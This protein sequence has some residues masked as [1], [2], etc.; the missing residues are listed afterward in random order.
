MAK[1]GLRAAT[2]DPE[3][4]PDDPRSDRGAGDAAERKAKDGQVLRVLLVEDCEEDSLLLRRTLEQG[5]YAPELYRVEDA[6]GLR[7]ALAEHRW[8]IVLSDYRLPRFTA[9]DALRIIQES[10]LDLPFILV[11]GVVGESAAVQIMK[12]GAHDFVSKDAVARLVP[13]IERELRE[14]DVR[15]Q[16]RRAEHARREEAQISSS[17]ARV[18]KQLIGSM[19]TR[20]VL[21]RLCS[22]AL[23]ELG[24]DASQSFLWESSEDVYLRIS[25]AG[26]PG[27]PPPA[28]GAAKISHALLGDFLRR[29]EVEE[30]AYLAQ[31]PAD[32]HVG[33]LLCPRAP[34]CRSMVTALRR[35]GQIFGFLTMELHETDALFSDQQAR[36]LQGIAQLGALAFENARLV[37]QLER[38]NQLKSEFIATMSHELRTPLNVI[39]G[40]N[41]LLMDNEFGPLSREQTDI[42]QRADR[43]ARELLGL[44]NATLDVS[45]LDVGRLPL[46][47][48]DVSVQD[49]IAELQA[50][51]GPL[52]QKDGLLSV[53]WRTGP[54]LPPTLHTDGM[55]LKI[56]LKHLLS[57][58]MKVS[59]GGRIVFRAERHA[60]CLLIEL[61][62]VAPG[63][64]AVDPLDGKGARLITE[65]TI[66]PSDA[67]DLELYVGSRLLELLGAKVHTLRQ[68]GC[69]QLLR[70][71]LP[72]TPSP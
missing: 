53:D 35:G 30:V 26:R 10:G 8:D 68:E 11:S 33:A 28:K 29:L 52:R 1:D 47:L 42:V 5:G 21:D 7:A 40:Y 38:A 36:Q 6:G 20:N 57:N 37:D 55:K 56:A 2:P 60:D 44:I 9:P 41:D 43:N 22:L 62:G 71:L 32:R 64:T 23:T 24:C 65:G 15:R 17:L 66:R 54:D 61:I 70:V 25:A 14:A 46:E 19:G 67:A 12:A 72:L 50:E 34:H 16:R 69:A 45:R 27:G 18:G 31:S 48:R 49:L 39:I 58:V 13:A 63:P 3:S 59:R 4:A 51:V